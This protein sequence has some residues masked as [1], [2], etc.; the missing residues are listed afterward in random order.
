MTETMLCA[1]YHAKSILKI[2]RAVRPRRSVTSCDLVGLRQLVDLGC[3]LVLLCHI[4]RREHRLVVALRQRN[5]TNGVV[6]KG[7]EVHTMLLAHKT[8]LVDIHD[9]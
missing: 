4:E 6:I 2:C 9:V 8:Y 3:L 5:A 1:S 7:Y